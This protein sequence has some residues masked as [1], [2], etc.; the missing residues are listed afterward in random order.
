MSTHATIRVEYTCFDCNKAIGGAAV[1]F[2][3]AAA[4]EK[5]VGKECPM[6]GKRDAET[7]DLLCGGCF[8]KRET[9]GKATNRPGGSGR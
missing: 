7:N 1:V 5:A 8:S 2:E 4:F 3:N 9:G 6:N